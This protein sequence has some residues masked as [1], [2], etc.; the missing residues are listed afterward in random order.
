MPEP[1][2]VKCAPCEGTGTIEW[3]GGKESGILPLPLAAEL[4][5]TASGALCPDEGHRSV[6][7]QSL[8]GTSPCFGCAGR[9]SVSVVPISEDGPEECE[10]CVGFGLAANPENTG[11]IG[12]GGEV[13]YWASDST[14]SPQPV[15]LDICEECGGSGWQ[16]RVDSN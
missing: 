11:L 3:V 12:P 14:G 16:G 5:S 15:N 9:G 8:C 1:Q 4:I 6:A 10:E 7:R 13:G 2:S